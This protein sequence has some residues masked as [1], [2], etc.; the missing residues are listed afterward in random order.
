M[1]SSKD[2]PAWPANWPSPFE[3]PEGWTDGKEHL[4]ALDLT[5]VRR[6]TASKGF[7]YWP[8]VINDRV[9]TTLQDTYFQ[10]HSCYGFGYEGHSYGTLHFEGAFVTVLRA[11]PDPRKIHFE[12]HFSERMEDGAQI[13]RID[14]IF[15]VLDIPDCE[16]YPWF[17]MPSI[18]PH[19][20]VKGLSSFK[21]KQQQDYFVYLC[22]T[23]LSCH[24]GAA[25]SARDGRETKGK[26]IWGEEISERL[27]SGAFIERAP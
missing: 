13:W 12:P 22:E 11:H 7:E 25:L 15:R 1:A 6:Y 19:V 3:K 26:V 24:N 21:D 18:L 17:D 4:L 20:E 8:D 23:L 9:S 10:F 2:T 16:K 27:A 5:K 14:E